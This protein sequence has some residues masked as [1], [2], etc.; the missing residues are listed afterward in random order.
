MDD[1]EVLCLR[2]GSADTQ[3]PPS[4]DPLKRGFCLRCDKPFQAVPCPHCGSYRV[5][6]SFGVSGARY[7]T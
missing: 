6:G 2:C 5:E 7:Q 1:T 4:S 3:V